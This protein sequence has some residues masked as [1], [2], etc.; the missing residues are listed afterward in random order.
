MGPRRETV[1]HFSILNRESKTRKVVPSCVM[2]HSSSTAA[3][4]RGSSSSSF[5]KVILLRGSSPSLSSRRRGRKWFR[6]RL[7]ALTLLLTAVLGVEEQSQ[8][9]REAPL[10][11][12]FP[13]P[14]YSFAH[15][16]ASGLL[17]EHTMQAYALA[18][19]QVSF[20]VSSRKRARGLRG[21][22][23]QRKKKVGIF[24][25]WGGRERVALA[26]ETENFTFL[27]WRLRS[28]AFLRDCHLVGRDARPSRHPLEKDGAFARGF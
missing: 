2:L 8:K 10:E 9:L 14:P 23:E 13:P 19:E 26:L 17:P 3:L 16:G 15:R 6:P 22:S 11:V 7:V 24:L 20:F 4:E 28:C 18:V 12:S 1:E 21:E 25:F 5:S 27:S